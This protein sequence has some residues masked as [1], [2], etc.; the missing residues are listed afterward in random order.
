MRIYIRDEKIKQT[1][2]PFYPV[3]AG[4]IA[5]GDVLNYSIGE[6]PELAGANKYA[7][8]DWIEIVNND[9]VNVEVWVG[10]GKFIVVAGTIRTIDN[11]WYNQFSV[12]NLDATSAT[13]A[14]K[15]RITCRRE[16]LTWDKLA[17]RLKL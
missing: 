8:L 11:N 15:I 6:S 7:P 1:G 4:A 3:S 10:I 17:R 16:P 13:T 14:D 5:A 12:H 9:S 2:S